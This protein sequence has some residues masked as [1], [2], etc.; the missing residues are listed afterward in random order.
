MWQPEQPS[1]QTV[2]SRGLAHDSRASPAPLEVR[3]E[4]PAGLGAL[5]D[6]AALLEQRP[7]R[8]DL[9]ALAAAGAG[10]RLPPGGAEVGDHP[11]VDAPAHHV[12]GVGALDL[13]ADPHAA[14][15]HDTAVVVDGEQRVAGVDADPRVDRRQLEVGEPE[16]LRPGPGARSGCWPRTP[17]RCG[18]APRTASP[19]SCAGSR[20]AARSG[21]SPPCPPRPRSRRPAGACPTPPTSTTHRRQAPTS[22][23]PS[24]WHRVGMSM[25]FSAATSR[26]D[27]PA[28]PAT[29]VPSM[30][31]VWTLT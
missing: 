8:A 27:W 16:G 31:R 28:A 22:L 11:G 15:A 25:P 19:R 17:S 14:G 5:G 10:G 9:D 13:V 4:G 7:G 3:E 20:P 21:R 29:S 23:R 24:R 6:R 30:R 1:S 2:A 26:I 18:C 12:P